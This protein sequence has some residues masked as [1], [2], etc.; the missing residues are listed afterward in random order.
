MQFWITK[1]PLHIIV[2][3]H[4]VFRAYS[5]N[6]TQQQANGRVGGRSEG[7]AVIK[8]ASPETKPSVGR[9]DVRIFLSCLP[10]LNGLGRAKYVLLVSF[11]QYIEAAVRL[12]CM[13][14]AI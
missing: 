10:F 6:R 13:I 11:V 12:I 2:C 14:K 8:Q 4:V 7:V 3:S 1:R 5:C 9:I